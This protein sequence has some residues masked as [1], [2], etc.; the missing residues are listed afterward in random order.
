MTERNSDLP[1]QVRQILL[2]RLDQFDVPVEVR[3]AIAADILAAMGKPERRAGAT[4]MT[5]ES[6]YAE[7]LARQGKI[8][9]KDESLK[10]KNI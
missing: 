4:V 7:S 1:S 10:P 5:P 8:D 2:E 3:K 6:S 9:A